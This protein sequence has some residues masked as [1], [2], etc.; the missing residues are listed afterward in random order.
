MNKHILP[1]VAALG[2]VACTS[3]APEP[4]PENPQQATDTEAKATTV[5]Y[6][7]DGMT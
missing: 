6:K 1:F 3:Q 2:L 4:A 5:S 7:I